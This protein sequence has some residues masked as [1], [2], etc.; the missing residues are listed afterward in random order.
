M[1]GVKNANAHNNVDEIDGRCDATT[2][3]FYVSQLRNFLA[4]H[5]NA[6][7]NCRHHHKQKQ[8]A[9][10]QHHLSTYSPNSL[11]PKSQQQHKDFKRKCKRAFYKFMKGLLDERKLKKSKSFKPEEPIYFEVRVY[12]VCFFFFIQF[13]DYVSH[14]CSIEFRLKKIERERK[15]ASHVYMIKQ[16]RLA[17]NIANTIITRSFFNV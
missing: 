14:A 11:E 5:S 16:N 13:I 8:V 3:D 12:F 4:K 6:S 17:A 15:K 2:N 7:F 10:H 1:F 9:E